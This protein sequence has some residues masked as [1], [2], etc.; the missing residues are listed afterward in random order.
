MATSQPKVAATWQSGL[1]L[2][3][4][5]HLVQTQNWITSCW[6]NFKAGDGIKLSKIKDGTPEVKLNL[7]IDIDGYELTYGEDGKAYIRKTG[8]DE[9][10]ETETE[11]GGENPSSDDQDIPGDPVPSPSTTGSGKGG[12]DSTCNEWSYDVGNPMYTPPE[13]VNEDNCRTLN[14][15]S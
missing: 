12:K 9:E 15:W 4:I 6:Q 5:E 2:G 14:G 8:S 11:P 1:Q 13:N 7:E 10:E 3:E